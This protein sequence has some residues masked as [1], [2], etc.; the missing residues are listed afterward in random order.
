MDKSEKYT[1]EEDIEPDMSDIAKQTQKVPIVPK[2]PPVDDDEEY[3]EDYTQSQ[4]SSTIQQQIEGKKKSLS[5]YPIPK[6]FNDISNSD[7]NKQSKDSNS[8][9]PLNLE[10]DTPHRVIKPD[11]GG[12][13]ESAKK[14]LD[15]KEKK[16]LTAKLNA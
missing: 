3:S 13:G 2:R 5:K 1:D 10:D 16:M 11:G 7:S 8:R 9:P 15:A 4:P 14:P 6:S 12:T